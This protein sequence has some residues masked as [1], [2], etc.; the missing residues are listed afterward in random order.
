MRWSF[1]K[2]Q[3]KL[4]IISN[5]FIL[6]F[7]DSDNSL[8][9]KQVS[10][11]FDSLIIT[12]NLTWNKRFIPQMIWVKIKESYIEPLLNRKIILPIMKD[13]YQSNLSGIIMETNKASM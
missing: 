6:Q 8:T 3:Q 10:E 13:T 9:L 7:I 4:G 11:T 5:T 12:K 1:V 2:F